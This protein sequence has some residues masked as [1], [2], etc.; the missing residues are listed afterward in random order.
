MEE[1]AAV[2]ITTVLVLHKLPTQLAVQAGSH[3]DTWLRL[4]QSF[5][6]VAPERRWACSSLVFP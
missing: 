2:S 6:L 1:A 4:V 5:Q 3:N